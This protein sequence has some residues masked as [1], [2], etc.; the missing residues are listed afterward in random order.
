MFEKGTH[1]VSLHSYYG[2]IKAQALE[3]EDMLCVICSE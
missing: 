1:G 2:V 3:A